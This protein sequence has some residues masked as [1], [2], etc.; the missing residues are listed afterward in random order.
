MHKQLL[1]LHNAVSAYFSGKNSDKIIGI[2]IFL[3]FIIHYYPT[4]TSIK[5]QEMLLRWKEQLN[6]SM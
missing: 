3:Y 6:N 1:L 2:F 4:I 5:L